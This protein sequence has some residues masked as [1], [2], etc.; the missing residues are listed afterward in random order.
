[1]NRTYAFA[2]R[3][4]LFPF[5]YGLSYTS[6]RFENLRVEPSQMNGEGTTVVSTDVVNTGT[7]AGDEVAQLY[8][9]QRIAS[10]TR[11]VMELKGF[12]RVKLQPGER[13]TVKFRLG[14]D[15]LSIFDVD[16]HR[17]IEPG[18][19]D[20]MVGPNSA[21]TSAVALTVVKPE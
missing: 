19:F 11:P 13:K 15:E 18:M 17:V 20:V 21:Q 4:P 5:G 7:R 12:Q 14:S 9:H 8:I 1:M 2:S 16:M 10:V 6:F 3:T